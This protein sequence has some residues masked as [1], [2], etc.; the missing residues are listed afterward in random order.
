MPILSVLCPYCGAGCRLGLRVED[1]RAV[2]VEYLTDHPVALGALC[3]KGN[4][5]HEIIGHPDRLQRPLVR[6]NGQFR[7]V[8][9]DEAL[10]RVARNLRRIHRERGPNA[11]GFL[12]SAKA[13]N[14][15]NYLFQKLARLLGT[16]NVDHCARLCHAPSVVGLRR[17]LGSGAMTN[18]IP[19]L[20]NSRCILIIGSNFAENHPVVT[21]WVWEAKDRGAFVV[22]A[23]P[24]CTPTARMA[25]L[26][27][28]LRPGTDVALLNGM[29]AAI[30]R[31]GLA[32]YDFIAARTEGVEGLRAVLTDFTLELAASVTGLPPGDIL[33][34]ARAYARSPASALLYCMGVTQHTVGTD[35][36]LACA[37]LALLCGQVGRPGTGLFPLRGQ[38]NVQ[39]AS[40]MGALA[41]L[42]PGYVPVADAEG[43]RRLAQLWRR[44]D[45]P[46]S[47]GLSVVEL[48]EAALEGRVRAMVVMGENPVVSDPASGETMRALEGLEFLVVQD[49]FLTE[50]ARLAHV[51][52]PAACWAEKSGSYTN[53]ERRVQWSPK[54]V[55]PPGEARPDLDIIGELGRRLGLWKRVPGPEAVLAEINRAVPAYGGI[56][57]ERLQAAPEGIFWPSPDSTHPGTPI[58][59]RER[60]AT[61]SGRGRFYS[62]AY[63]PP[64]EQPDAHFSL[65][66]TTG[67]V[68]VHYNSG[69]LSRRLPKLAAYAPEVWVAI[70]PQDARRLGVQDGEVVRV[71][72]PRGDVQARVQL[73]DHV[74]PGLVFL[75]FHFP[76]VNALTLKELDREARIPSYKVAACTLE[77]VAPPAEEG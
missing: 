54:A 53:T 25:D 35:N 46:D 56:T 71:R 15:E 3:P 13:T 68:V 4:V 66:M 43:R 62:V 55:E 51:V 33:R 58:L 60:F 45:L 76:G 50:T 29:A 44:E 74:Q 69:S 59:H 77:R 36:V 72:S 42:L 24:R 21:R 39:G 26:Y 70:H 48:M 41:E 20:A 7:E 10:D 34:A 17:A 8:G 75:P 32:N 47:P 61:P 57:P 9:W 19:D 28:P 40:D 16:N 31:E 73:S 23:D 18:P 49:L 52:L 37:N 1:G 38:N 65:W 2:G 30:L 63:Q 5:A 27:L 6:E 11:L 14:E 12:A 22:V 64:P 67:R